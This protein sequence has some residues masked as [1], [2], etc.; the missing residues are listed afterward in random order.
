MVINL[1]GFI[2]G[3]TFLDC[4]S[5]CYLLKKLSAPLSQLILLESFY[6]DLSFQNCIKS[7]VIN[8][9]FKIFRNLV[10]DMVSTTMFLEQNIIQCAQSITD[11]F[12]RYIFSQ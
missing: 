6:F 10:T 12:S 1:A 9:S 11:T 3:G 2:K 4:L 5:N 7:A 8:L